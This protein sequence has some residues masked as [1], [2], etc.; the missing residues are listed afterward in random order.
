MQPARDR[1]VRV[2]QE[3]GH[4]E[5]PP[6]WRQPVHPVGVHVHEHGVEALARAP[7]PDGDVHQPADAAAC[8]AVVIHKSPHALRRRCGLNL[9]DTSVR[10]W[11]PIMAARAGS[12]S[13][14]QTLSAS[15]ATSSTS[16]R[17][18]VTP[19]ITTSRG[20]A[21]AV[22]TAA[23]PC[24]AASTRTP[25]N[26]SAGHVSSTPGAFPSELGTSHQGLEP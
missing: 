23:V 19:L 25:A 9:T 10:A 22:E 20:P 4:A 13:R 3:H 8:R 5:A 26:P 2:P 7:P 6:A 1:A 17:N 12:R 15:A 21:D 14:T 16:C 18:P 11:A 24:D